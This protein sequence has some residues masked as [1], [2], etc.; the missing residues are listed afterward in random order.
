MNGEPFTYWLIIALAIG[1]AVAFSSWRVE[2][3]SKPKPTFVARRER[4]FRDY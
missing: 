3:L 1:A 2:K 4:R